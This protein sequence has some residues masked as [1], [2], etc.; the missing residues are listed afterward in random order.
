MSRNAATPKKMTGIVD[1]HHLLL[2][3][4][5]FEEAV[6]RLVA[7]L[8]GADRSI[9]RQQPVKL[10][11]HRLGIGI[12]R[13]RNDGIVEGA[14]HVEGGFGRAAIDPQ[15]GVESIVRDRDPRLHRI[16][17]FGRQRDAGNVKTLHAS[18]KHDAHRGSGRH[19]IRLRKGF[20][21]GGAMRI[22]RL[23]RRTA[24]QVQTRKR[25]VARM[26]ERYHPGGYRQDCGRPINDDVA[27]D[28]R[29]DRGDAG[30][31]VEARHDGQ[32]GTLERDE[33]LR[34]ARIRIEAI[35]P[36]LQRIVCRNRG[37]EYRDTRRHHQRNRE[38]LSPHG[39]NITQEFA[40]E[41]AHQRTSSGESR[42]ALCC[43][44]TM[45][46]PPSRSTRSAMP[47][48]AALWVMTTVVVPSCSLTRAIAASTTLPVS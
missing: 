25:L 34:E 45:R 40:I 20:V 1:R 7:P 6:G 31:F 3:K 11:D 48:I 44:S 12:A 21:D 8:D 33:N 22:A 18:I 10:V 29:L 32:R 9:G 47:A 26:G 43:S 37:D 30:N 14:F 24:T 15:D 41:Q 39:G 42:R 28:A 19:P 46:P 23:R 4:L 13:E 16:D 5:V 17:V 38:H 2:V 27:H 36:G 35:A